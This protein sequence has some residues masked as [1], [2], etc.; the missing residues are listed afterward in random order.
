MSE[1]DRFRVI[2]GGNRPL[3]GSLGGQVRRLFA[4]LARIAAG[5]GKPEEVEA[6]MLELAV[7]IEEAQQRSGVALT[8]ERL[9]E[10]LDAD[11][12]EHF[13]A[14]GGERD[15]ER[16]RRDGTA[17]RVYAI[18]TIVRGALRL[19]ASR[20]TANTTQEQL[21]ESLLLNGVRTLDELQARLRAEA[22]TARRTYRQ[23]LSPRHRAIT[24]DARR[25]CVGRISGGNRRG[26]L[27]PPTP[28]NARV[29]PEAEAAHNQ[30]GWLRANET[31]GQNRSEAALIAAQLCTSRWPARALPHFPRNANRQLGPISDSFAE[32]VFSR[33][34]K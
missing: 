33:Q 1:G 9:R 20:V 30:F 29:A 7:A 23:S 25:T 13:R 26:G 21:A 12:G 11:D 18:N 15:Q 6:Q 19:A 27:A 10:W 4:N 5:A 8:D 22:Q 24:A 16:W 34:M 3:D 32:K 14:L 28:L 31:R 17:E 2:T